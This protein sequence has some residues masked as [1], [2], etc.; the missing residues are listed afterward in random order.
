MAFYVYMLRCADDS[1]YTGHTDNL[2]PRLAAHQRGTFKGY[3][4][5]RRPL[6]LLF[7]A[8]FPTREE[9]IAAERQIKGWC[10]A[11]KDALSEDDWEKIKHLARI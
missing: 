8:D 7:T 1:I 3:T 2:M 9:A 6:C 5:T 4:S 11:K 10:R